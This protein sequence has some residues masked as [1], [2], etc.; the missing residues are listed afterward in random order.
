MEL[1]A[2][3]RF[4]TM[5]TTAEV[6]IVGGDPHLL[7]QAQQ[8]LAALEARWS[9]F[10]PGSD[11]SELN[12]EAGRSVPVSWETQLL[13][14]R[15]IAAAQAT[16]GR[17][18]PTIGAALIAHGYDRTFSEVTSHAIEVTPVPIIDASWPAIE[19][20]EAAGTACLPVDTVFDPGGIGKGLAADLVAEELADLVDGILVNLGGDV[21]MCGAAADPAGW[22][23][24]VDDP[25][26]PNRELTRL[27]IPQGAIATSSKRERSWMTAAG[28]AHHIID[29]RTG[30]PVQTDV[31]AVTV[32]AAEAWWAETQATSLFLQGAEG[33]AEAGASIE[34]LMVLDDGSQVA[35]AG[36]QQVLR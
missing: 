24:S 8:R 36:F 32:L 10:R 30:R 14:R 16:Q 5:G 28:P 7:H 4:A 17:F 33:L 20:D 34:A 13:L 29:P 31:A 19:V 12:R 26:D 27:A 15:A 22:V 18:D 25:F 9:R 3:E 11:I 2:K 6:Q 1:I 35:T 21:R 23:I